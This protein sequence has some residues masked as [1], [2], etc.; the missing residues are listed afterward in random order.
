MWVHCR[1]FFKI[2]F[3][4]SGLKIFCSEKQIKYQYAIDE[5]GISCHFLMAS[6]VE[7]STSIDFRVVLVFIKTRTIQKI[8]T[9]RC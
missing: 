6:R 2:C 9:H 7:N 4:F 8:V 1:G 5:R 3:N